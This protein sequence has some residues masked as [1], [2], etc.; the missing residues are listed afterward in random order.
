MCKA[1]D[2]VLSKRR[3]PQH[4]EEVH[5]LAQCVLRDFVVVKDCNL[6]KNGKAPLCML[7]LCYTAKEE[8]SIPHRH[9]QLHYIKQHKTTHNQHNTSI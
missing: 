9:T 5:S 3:A 2:I 1:C 7:S 4:L 6:L 8:D